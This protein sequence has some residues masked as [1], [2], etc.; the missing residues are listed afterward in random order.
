VILLLAAA[1]ASV[2]CLALPDA[3]DNA[4]L[5]HNGF[6]VRGVEV[7]RIALNGDEK[8]LSKLVTPDA[9]FSLGSGDVGLPMGTGVQGAIRFAKELKADSYA[10]NGWDYIPST[11]NVCDEYQIEV[12]FMTSDGLDEAPVKFTFRGG[13][14]A[15]ASGWWRSRIS[16]KVNG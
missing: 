11:R 9:V 5:Q 16:G 4:G 12:R 6:A 1:S 2:A 13:R 14:L 3:G 7:V 8:A 15:E 10:F